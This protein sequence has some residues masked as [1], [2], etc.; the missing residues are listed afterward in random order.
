M[1]F[2][3][4]NRP[5][6]S[7]TT[8]DMIKYIFLWV[9][10]V[11]IAIANGVIKQFWYG[12]HLGELPAH[13][14]SSLIGIVLLGVYILISLRFFP[15]A[16]AAQALRIGVLW[17]SLTIVFEFI[18]GHFIAGHS[19]S[20]LFQDYNLFAGRLWVLVLI[21]ITAAPYIFYRGLK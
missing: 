1:I 17:L 3:M 9:P 11:F 15:P 19:W 13:Q 6:Q 10:M 7:K 18:F 2:R 4:N 20:R 12:R 21:W 8:P 16:G 14:L 5:I